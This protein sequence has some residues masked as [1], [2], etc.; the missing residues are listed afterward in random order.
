VG[1][2]A[3]RPGIAGVAALVLV[4]VLL[5]GCGSDAKDP[6]TVRRE[7]VEAR[8]QSS[9][10]DNQARC[11]AKA[12]DQPTLRALDLGRPLPSGSKALARYS[13]A[14]ARCV[15]GTTTPSTTHAATTTTTTG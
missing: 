3:V 9:F 1:R 15:T 7:R 5:G 4:G 10:S 12:L 6:A 14:V 2:D 13:D 8:L 11:I